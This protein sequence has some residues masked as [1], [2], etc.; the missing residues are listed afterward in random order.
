[1]TE[2][3]EQHIRE[4]V[5]DAALAHVRYMKGEDTYAPTGTTSMRSYHRGA[6]DALM[7]VMALLSDCDGHRM[8]QAEMER[9]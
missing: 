7:A 6:V 3:R 1:M 2:D 5:R 8:V 9:A 4:C